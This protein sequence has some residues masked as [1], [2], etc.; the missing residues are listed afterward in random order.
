[1]KTAKK[2]IAF[3]TVAVILISCMGLPSYAYGYRK[4]TALSVSE[5]IEALRGQFESFTGPKKNGYAL[6]S[7]FYSPVGKNDKTK[8]PIVIF[9]HGIGHGDY[10]GSQLDDSLMPYWSSCE[11]QSRF[12]DAGGAFILLP[13]APEDQKTYWNEGFIEPLRALIDTFIAEH[14]DNVDTT[15]I[16]VTGSSAGGGMVWLM[17]EAFPGLFSCAFP[18]ASTVTPSKDTIKSAAGTAIWILASQKDPVVN[19]NFSTLKIWKNVIKTNNNPQNCRLSTFQKVYKPDGEPASDNHHLATVITY[20]LH[21][22]DEGVYPDVETIDGNGNVLDLTSPNGIIT[23]I[24][25]IHSDYDGT[26]SEGHTGNLNYSLW[27]RICNAYQDWLYS[28]VH[29]FQIALGLT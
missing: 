19:Y 23:W 16:A 7:K 12:D 14:K 25:S 17:L 4:K 6:D 8:Y 13:R 1:M 9:L 28:V 15:R 27:T 5:G 18:L 11:F 2:I 24:S 21:T 10:E 26:P 3:L 29:V 20:D 22:I